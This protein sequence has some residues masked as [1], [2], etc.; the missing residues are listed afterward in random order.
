MSPVAD[1]A[2]KR[3]A[4]RMAGTAS[5]CRHV[6]GDLDSAVMEADHVTVMSGVVVAAMGCDVISTAMIGR[7]VSGNGKLVSR[8]DSREVGETSCNVEL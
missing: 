2:E 3:D 1:A 8:A 5:D 4:R 6:R 7:S